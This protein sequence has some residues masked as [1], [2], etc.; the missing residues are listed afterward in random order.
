MKK[1]EDL[2]IPTLFSGVLAIKKISPVNFGKYPL[3]AVV[4]CGDKTGEE[5]GRGVP[6]Y[7]DDVCAIFPP[8]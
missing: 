7:K 5:K 8:S 6:L 2:F 3:G 4:V 1:F